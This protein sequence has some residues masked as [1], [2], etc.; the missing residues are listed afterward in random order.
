MV[1]T[2][3]KVE[4]MAFALSD[5]LRHFLGGEQKEKKA[6][7][8]DREAYDFCREAYK[9]SGGVPDELRRAHEFY[10]NH[11]KDDSETGCRSF[12]PANK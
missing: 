5:V 7:K 3:Q 11:F 6:F 9:E 8:T 10:V 2:D 4:V 1:R 12:Q